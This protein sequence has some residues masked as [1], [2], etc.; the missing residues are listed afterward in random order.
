ML[1]WLG[2][3]LRLPTILTLDIQVNAGPVCQELLQFHLV[4][5]AAHLV[6][7]R[8]VFDDKTGGVSL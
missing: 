6:I 3:E 1:L 7:D 5:K 8:V 2:S 4:T